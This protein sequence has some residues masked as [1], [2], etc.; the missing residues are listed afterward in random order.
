MRGSAA[1]YAIVERRGGEE[2]LH[3]GTYEEMD[4]PSRLVFTLQ[5]PK[6]SDGRQ[7]GRDRHRAA[8]SGQQARARS[9]RGEA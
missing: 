5:V 1:E 9:R 3:T 4:R 7:P 6:F 2:M 8:G